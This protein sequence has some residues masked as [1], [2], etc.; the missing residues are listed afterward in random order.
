ML[1]EYYQ[2]EN[3]NLKSPS[4]QSSSCQTIKM[5]MRFYKQY[6]SALLRSLLQIWWSYVVLWAAS[7]AHLLMELP[8]DSIKDQVLILLNGSVSGYDV[9]HL[10]CSFPILDKLSLNFQYSFFN[11]S[12][13]FTFC[14][15]LIKLVGIDLFFAYSAPDIHSLGK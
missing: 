13:F 3:S 6:I 5:I 15:V 10:I 14:W 2:L 1:L 9:V 4:F 11:F 8:C 12:Y 7:P